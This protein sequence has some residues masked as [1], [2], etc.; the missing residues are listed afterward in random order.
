MK[1]MIGNN[2]AD[3]AANALSLARILMTTSYERGHLMQDA[4]RTYMKASIEN[5]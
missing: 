3:S 1:A 5:C 2:N 4:L